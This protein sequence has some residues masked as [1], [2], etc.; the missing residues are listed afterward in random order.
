MKRF[1]YLNSDTLS[2]Y[3]SQIDD[4]LIKNKIETSKK[5]Y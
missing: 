4:G 2:S 3:M 5:K 1:L